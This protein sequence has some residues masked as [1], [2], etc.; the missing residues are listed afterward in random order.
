MAQICASALEVPIDRIAVLHGT[1]SL[2][3]DGGGT[4]ASRNTVM[5]G[6]AVHAAAEALRR[7]CLELAALRWNTAGEALAFADG[8]VHRRAEPEGARL[9][10]A[11]LAAFAL[12]SGG[13]PLAA[14][15]QFDNGGRTTYTYGAHAAHVAVDPE[16]GEVEVIRYVVVEDIGRILNPMLAHGQA[17]GG[18]VQGLGGALLDRVVYGADGQL[19]TANLADCLLPVSLTAGDIHAVTLEEA[20][21]KLNPLGFKGAG[22]GGIVAVGAAVGNAIAD[23]LGANRNGAR[24]TRTPFDPEY[25]RD[26]LA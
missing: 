9:S 15:G 10:L 23:A 25:V 19:L 7:R 21:S 12:G 11:D 24:I 2:L 17:V 22:E 6:N 3:A 5:C 1:T 26:Q 4:Y 8:A 16:T 18:V 13:A 20:P 14:D